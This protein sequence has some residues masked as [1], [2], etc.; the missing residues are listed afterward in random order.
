MIYKIYTDG[1][2]KGNPGVAAAG[3]VIYSPIFIA[4]ISKP[5]GI[6]TNS[7]KLLISS[8]I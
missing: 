1:A 7:I 2:S 4:K 3:G 5:L 6:Q 8:L